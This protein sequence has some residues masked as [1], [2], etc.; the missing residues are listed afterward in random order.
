M[1]QER[2]TPA[3]IAQAERRVVKAAAPM[4][5]P[6]TGASTKIWLGVLAASC[7]AM[8]RAPAG[9]MVEWSTNVMLLE[10]HAATAAVTSSTSCV[11]KTLVMTISGLGSHT[12][13]LSEAHG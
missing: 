5:P 10:A 12:S 13:S 8:R 1:R 6:D 9:S 4:V 7:C 11:E 2:E 3:A